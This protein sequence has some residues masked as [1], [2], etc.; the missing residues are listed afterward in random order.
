MV[1]IWNVRGS[2]DVRR[3]L[4]QLDLSGG[5][6]VI[7]PNFFTHCEGY[8]TDAQ[9]LDLFLGAIP[10]GQ[11]VVECYT[12]A[13]TDRSRAI[14]PGQSREHLDWLRDQDRLFFA[15]SGIGAVLAKHDAEFLNVTEEIWGGRS[16]DAREV[17]Q[18]VE[19][20]YPPVMHPELYGCVPQ[21]LF[22]LRG[23][24]MLNLAKLKVRGPGTDVPFF[25][26]GMKNL[27]G[28][29]PEPNRSAYHGKGSS[30][31]ADSIVDMCKIYTALFDVTHVV[32][33]VY[34]TLIAREGFIDPDNPR[35]GLGLVRD[36]G[37]AVTGRDPVE[38]DALIVSQF[39]RDPAERHFLTAARGV[40]G[41]W[42]TA[43]FPL[44]PP[45]FAAF[46]AAYR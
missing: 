21:R 25:S 46:F 13:R 35:K 42:D 9:T 19:R 14:E 20:R 43:R 3:M 31:L 34:N 7:K 4:S 38:I 1:E 23:A 32:E 22:D 24:P 28:L 39:G 18:L 36:L 44:V 26:L 40:L 17:A 37:L 30:G 27:F 29:S 8:H 15:E 33:A 5:T 6:C 45:A 12:G 10:A 16:A 2:G 11:I 41:D